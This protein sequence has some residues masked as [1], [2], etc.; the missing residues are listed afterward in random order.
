MDTN[1]DLRPSIILT[2]IRT[3]K[4]ELTNTLVS[5]I[6]EIDTNP[7]SI[8]NANQLSR[9]ERATEQYKKRTNNLF[10]IGFLGHF[11]SGK[12]STINTL[13]KL[14]GTA[15]EKKTDH[16][17]TDDQIT[18]LTSINN[19]QDVIKLTRSGKVPIVI[20][21]VEGNDQLAD[22]VI[23]DTPGSG[24]PATFEEIVRDSLP[25]CDLIIYCFAASHPLT[26]SDIP[27]LKEK[28]KHLP[29]IPTVY[30]ITR[31]NEFRIDDYI[32]LKDSNFDTQKFRVF[33]SDLAARLKEVVNTI[34]IDHDE[35]IVIDNKEK[36]NIEKLQEQ[37]N[38]FCNPENY[39]NILRLHDLKINYFTK[40]LKEIKLYFMQLISMKLEIVEKYLTQAKIKLGEYDRD[41]LVGTDKMVNA[42]RIV[43]DRIKQSLDGA[44]SQNNI[45]HYSI[46]TPK[47]FLD[48]SPC[49]AWLS[50]YLEKSKSINVTK[51]FDYK[52]FTQSIL[53]DLKANIQKQIF[54]QIDKNI[55]L[56]AELL[57]TEIEHYSKKLLIATDRDFDLLQI[58]N[59]NS[60]A[61]F[62]Y[63]DKQSFID[64]KKNIDSLKTRTKNI[65]PLDSIQKYLNEAKMTLSDIFATYKS[66]VKIYTVAA[67]SIEAKSYIK[68][69]GLSDKLDL[70]DTSDPNTDFYLTQTVN[71]IFSDFYSGIQKFEVTCNNIFSKLSSITY[72]SP[73]ISEEK[74]LP[75]LKE[76]EQGIID[77][78]QS[79]F[80]DTLKNLESKI[81]DFFSNK[82]HAINLAVADL[83]IKKD[84]DIKKLR[85]QRVYYYL[86]KAWPFFTILIVTIL[87]FYLPS[88]FNISNS[89][90]IG[91]QW[92]FGILINL[93]SGIINTITSIKK[94]KHH[95][96]RNRIENKFIENEK[97]LSAKILENEFSKFS[98]DITYDLKNKIQEMLDNQSK[99]ILELVLL[100]K[101]N[102]SNT[103]LHISLIQ[104]E[105]YL[106][107]LLT[108]YSSALNELKITSLKVINNTTINKEILLKQSAL[109][110][111]NSINPSFRLLEETRNE[112]ADV[113]KKIELVDF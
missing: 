28:E 2:Q 45:V 58:H 1:Q 94:D 17:P 53:I 76:R 107:S 19:S 69:L 21:Y 100:E 89:L 104:T 51:S 39:G 47:E 109:L 22:K 14:S 83:V 49:R 75:E 73:V 103:A 54:N 36:F 72:A 24:D 85:E 41:T 16:N 66:G 35:F 34:N 46:A 44:I 57:E 8:E 9:I 77:F 56:S 4:T 62:E 27:L 95:L 98:S 86:K 112:I 65:N 48:L 110:K 59:E 90:S 63:F 20:T 18:L 10:Y 42:W 99:N 12:S 101:Y 38:K 15:N 70:I 92:I 6:L 3:L 108:D 71:D 55:S 74:N 82:I 40:T 60:Q 25:L 64:L 87:F 96:L 88:K 113:R 105:G 81:T 26:N 13:L 106:K 84:D 91:N 111:E 43:D 32:P 31:G 5:N 102:L 79:K 50:K 67:F 80:N 68:S 11:S 93:C 37:V 61:I 78:Y 29:E 7:E 97:N 33:A 52:A 23:M 30:L